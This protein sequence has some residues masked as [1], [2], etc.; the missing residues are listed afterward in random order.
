LTLS[1]ILL[2]V[3]GKASHAWGIPVSLSV[4]NQ[5]VAVDAFASALLLKY[6]FVGDSVFRVANT[7]VGNGLDV[8]RDIQ[9]VA[10]FL[11]ME[12]GNPPYT[13]AFGANG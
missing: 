13:D 9:H 11:G 2:A 3:N 6:R 8:M 10:E 7:E 12:E 1:D 4:V 5:F